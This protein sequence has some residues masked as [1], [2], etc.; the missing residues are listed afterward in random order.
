LRSHRRGILEWSILLLL[1]IRPFRCRQCSARH[2]AFFFRR[3][4]VKETGAA[5]A[6][7]AEEQAAIPKKI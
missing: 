5:V 4:R 3:R 6:E 2:L 7:P 1:L